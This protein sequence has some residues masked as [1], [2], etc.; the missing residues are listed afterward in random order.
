MRKTR[1]SISS[2]TAQADQHLC[3]SC[4]LIKYFYQSIYVFDCKHKK[5]INFSSENMCFTAVKIAILHRRA[6]VMMMYNRHNHLFVL[7]PNIYFGSEI[8]A[9]SAFTP[10]I[11]VFGV[12]IKGPAKEPKPV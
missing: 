8:C 12:V 4:F 5:N 6:R 2:L 7:G 9:S 11:F 3:F 10:A 1:A